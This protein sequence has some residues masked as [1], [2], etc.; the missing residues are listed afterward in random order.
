MR[1]PHASSCLPIRWTTSTEGAPM[2]RIRLAIAALALALA[3]AGTAAAAS[4]NLVA[5]S[6]P[7]TV[8]GKIIEA[9]QATPDGKDASCSPNDGPSTGQGKAGAAGLGADGVF[10]STGDD[11]NLLVDAGLVDQSW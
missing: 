7:K 10:L 5:Y 11:V 2:P 9:W 1:F 4:I 8:M 6:T 3:L